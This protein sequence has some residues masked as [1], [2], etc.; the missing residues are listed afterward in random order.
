MKERIYRAACYMRLSR[1][2]GDKAESDS[3]LNQ[4]RLLDDFCAAHPEF[5]IV[6]HYADDGYTGTNF[7][8]PAFQRLIHDIEAGRVD[9][10][11]VKDLSRFGRDYIATGFYLER[12]FPAKNVRFIAVNDHEDSINGPYNML[13]P[14]KN[15]FNTQYARDISEKVRSAFKTK[16]RRGEFIGAF[17]SYGYLKDPGNRNRL[18]I[19]PVA[20][21]VVAHIFQRAAEGV[22]QIR[23]AKELNEKGIP[24]PSDYKRL[25]GQ[26]YRNSR[27]LDA[28]HYWTYATVHRILQNEMYLGHMVQAKTVRSTMH[29][30]A[31]AAE[32]SAWISVPDTHPAIVSQEL[33]DTVQAQITKNTRG[34]DFDQNLG[35]FAGFLKCGDCGRALC[36]TNRQG[37]ISYSC[38]SYRRYGA[39]VC[40]SHTIRQEVLEEIVLH[41]LNRV[42][43]A[44][45]D[46]RAAA[47]RSSQE[48]PSPPSPERER[49]RLGAALERVQRLKQSSYEDYR[50]GLL[51]R[52]EFLRYKGDYDRQEATL[53]AQLEELEGREAKS[54]ESPWVERLLSLGALE[55]LD[56]ATVAQT[57]KEIRVHEGNRLEI[58]YLFS[59]DLAE[60][61]TDG[62]EACAL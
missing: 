39:G 56:R 25:M 42:I 11:L 53:N 47:Q 12:Y 52:E 18:V 55:E 17:A 50:E 24:C 49:Q 4:Q 29:G 34:I 33:W 46:L 30:K 38:G 59:G 27:K 32:R 61:L 40:T 60:L 41:D 13:L 3:I 16:Q 9:L 28:T 20:A 36:K 57:V 2:D 62:E 35:L 19:D 51:T 26:K 6:D 54:E 37:R 21:G 1:E 15:V 45:G 31:A 23:I 48:L 8:R 10:V 14:L 44:V 22:G 7:D 43:A 58:D 5:H